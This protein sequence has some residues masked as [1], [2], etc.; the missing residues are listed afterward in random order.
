[1]G[2]DNATFYRGD[3]GAAPSEYPG[4]AHFTRSPDYNS[5]GFGRNR[6]FRLN[7]QNAFLDDMPVTADQFG[8]LIQSAKK[9]DPKLASDLASLVGKD[10]DWVIGFG[11][12]RPGHVVD[13]GGAHIRYVIERSAA[14][15][16]VFK[17]A[18]FDAIGGGHEVRKLTGSGIRSADA[19]FNPALADQRNI[20]YANPGG[21][22]AAPFV[23]GQQDYERPY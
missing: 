21:A 20:M 10:A 7:L 1:M 3:K 12:A 15:E 14:P 8:R 23:S 22:A 6:E 11:K 18:G 5:G 17:D 4:G 16:L 13:D 9:H 2:Y 19:A